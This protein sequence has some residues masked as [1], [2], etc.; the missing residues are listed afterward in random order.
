MDTLIHGLRTGIEYLLVPFDAMPRFWALTVLSVASGVL[1]LWV[2]GKTTP[3]R[4]VEIARAR[5]A[6][7]IYEMRLFL[8]SPGR[9]LR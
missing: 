2:V 1:M 3:Q 6:S 4:R 7:A 9:I 8:D 5:M